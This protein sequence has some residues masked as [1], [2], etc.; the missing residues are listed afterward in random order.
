MQYRPLIAVAESPPCLC[1]APSITSTLSLPSPLHHLHNVLPFP[2]PS[3]PAPCFG[4]LHHQGFGVLHHQGFGVLYHQGFGVLHP[5]CPLQLWI[6]V[7]WV[8]SSWFHC[9]CFVYIK[10]LSTGACAN[11]TLREIMLINIISSASR[12]LH[13][14]YVASLF[15]SSHSCYTV[16]LSSVCVSSVYTGENSSLEVERWLE[17]FSF[18]L[19]FIMFQH[20]SMFRLGDS[21]VHSQSPCH[22]RLD[23]VFSY[24]GAVLM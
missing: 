22:C 8:F 20:T 6:T 19:Y 24:A 4:V 7:R 14:P 11:I 2:L 15:P 5:L 18:P 3:P 12:T 10:L 23:A 13:L 21:K 9:I 16:C 17:I 1:P